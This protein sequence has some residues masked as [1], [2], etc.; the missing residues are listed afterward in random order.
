[1]ID[2]TMKILSLKTMKTK[3]S[4][5]MKTMMETSMTELDWAGGEQLNDTGVMMELTFG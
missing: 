2:H 3:T 4:S 1:M 5:V